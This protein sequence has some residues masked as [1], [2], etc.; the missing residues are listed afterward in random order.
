MVFGYKL[1][2][3]LQGI[4][5]ARPKCLDDP[6][7]GVHKFFKSGGVRIHY[8]ESG[9]SS[10]PLVIF[11]HGFPDFWYTWKSQIK[12]F[13]KDYHVIAMDMR[14]YSESDKPAAVSDYFIGN[15]VEDIKNLAEHVNK[16]K[17]H[18][19]AHD[20]G[21]AVSWYFAATYPN[22][23][24]SYTACNSPHPTS[25]K[26]QQK[27]SWGQMFKSW[28]IM[29]FQMPILPEYMMMKDNL[30]MFNVFFKDAG[31]QKD[32][33]LINCYKYSFSDF[34]TWNRTISYYRA[35]YRTVLFNKKALE[36]YTKGLNK[37]QVPVM[38][39]FGTGDKYISVDSAKGSSKYCTDH[40]LELA[41][42]V[43]HWIQHQTPDLVNEKLQEFFNQYS[44]E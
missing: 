11:V 26:D 31:V 41:P 15:M 38:S 43:S 1:F 10:A 14:G 37:I 18:L 28:Y 24:Q 19:V 25:L 16:P 44:F 8:V 20:W 17:F 32:E 9:N 35:A 13:N 23:V 2:K 42:G 3:A 34:T 39:L 27:G 33:E 29:F 30:K 22:M 40:K 4:P 12:F 36:P 7:L 6:S 21:G 5:R